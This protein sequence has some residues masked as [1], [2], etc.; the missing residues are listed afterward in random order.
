MGSLMS[1]CL[2]PE[3][4]CLTRESKLQPVTAGEIKDCELK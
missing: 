1:I 2:H 3:P 4:P